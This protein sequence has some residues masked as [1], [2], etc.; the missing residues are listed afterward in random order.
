MH[1]HDAR[2]NYSNGAGENPTSLNAKEDNV[3]G[4]AGCQTRSQD[5]RACFF[6][7]HFA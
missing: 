5:G 1:I 7:L 2:H 6:R 3:E 4:I